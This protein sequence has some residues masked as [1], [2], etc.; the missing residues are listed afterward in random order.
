MEFNRK[1][2]RP[3]FLPQ[4]AQRTQRN[5]KG[6]F[7][8]FFVPFVAIFWVEWKRRGV[9]LPRPVRAAMAAAADRVPTPSF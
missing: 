6:F 5:P 2:K 4:R 7:F 8:E 1:S 9:Y 3:V